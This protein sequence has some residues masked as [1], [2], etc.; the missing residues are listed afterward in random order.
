MLVGSFCIQFPKM[1]LTFNSLVIDLC[2]LELL[3]QPSEEKEKGFL[4]AQCTFNVEF[5]SLVAISWVTLSCH[6]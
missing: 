6:K 4:G 3:V 5:L 2:H 1:L